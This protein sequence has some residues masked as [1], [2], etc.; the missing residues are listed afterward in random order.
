M[1][2]NGWECPNS[3]SAFVSIPI[4]SQSF[5][6]ILSYSRSFPSIPDHSYQFPPIP[7]HSQSFKKER[8][9]GMVEN[10]WECPNSFFPFGD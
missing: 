5:S 7:R 10:G 6:S 8:L 4:H 1:D 2:V 9:I 3:L